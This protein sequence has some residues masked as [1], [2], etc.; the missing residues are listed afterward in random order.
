MRVLIPPAWRKSAALVQHLLQQQ[1]ADVY[2]AAVPYMAG[3]TLDEGG[4]SEEEHLDLEKL[5]HTGTAAR[6][7]QLLKRTQ[8]RTAGPP[9][10]RNCR[11]GS[12]IKVLPTC[13]PLCSLLCVL[14]IRPLLPLLATLVNRHSSASLQALHPAAPLLVIAA[15]LPMLLP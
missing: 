13:Q 5:H 3:K 9:N 1:G 10:W 12:P 11:G 4:L 6:V 2:V 7:L 8:A 14:Y 15:T